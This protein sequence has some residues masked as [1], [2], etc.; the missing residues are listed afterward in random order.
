M[1]S[2]LHFLLALTSLFVSFAQEP[3]QRDSIT[4]L[5]E[6]ILLDS[7]QS[8]TDNGII[9]TKIIGTK[10]FQNYSPVD[11]VSAINQIS[12]VYIL[13]GALNTNRITIRGVGAR[14]LFGTDKL[15]LYYND[16]PITNGSGFSTI[17]SFDLENLSS[18][19]VIKGPKATNYGAN[20]GGAILLNSKQPTNESTYFRNNFTVGSYSLV[21]NNLQ[22]SLKEN[23]VALNFHYGFLETDG[24]RENNKFKRE[25]VLLDLNYQITPKTNIGLLFNHV[26]YN[27]Q[28]PSSLGETDFRENPTKAAFTWKS[29]KGYE[30][31]KYSLAG[32]TLNHAFSAKLSN[33]T[34]IFY[35]YLDHYEPRPFGILEEYTNGYGFR[36]KFAGHW[37]TNNSKIDYNFGAELYKDEYQWSEFENL[38]QDNNGQGS[39][40]GDQFA[41]NKEFRRQFNAFGNLLIPFGKSFSTQ[42]GLNVNKTYY[43]F[44]D[45]FN[46]GADNKSAER[47]FDAIVLP[48]LNLNYNFSTTKSIYAN[49]SRGFSNPTVEETLT[50]DGVINPDIAQETGV[51][52]EIGSKLLLL[53][54]KLSINLALYRMDIKNLLVAQRVGEDQYIGK[55]AGKTQ[56][57]GLELDMEYNWDIASKLRVT[58]FISYTYNDHSFV[59]FVDGDNNY[60]GNPLTGVPKHRLNSGLQAQ[61]NNKFY[62]YSTHQYVGEIPLTDANELYSD[63]FNVV[64][65]KVGYKNQLGKKLSMDIAFGINNIFDRN[66]A[67]SVLINTTGFG[68]AEPRYYYPGN[69]RNYYGSLRLGYSL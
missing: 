52:Y 45:E 25:G 57:Q 48:S 69:D 21:K 24:Y 31:N 56:H 19:E 47:D 58:P 46:Q 65:S 66:Y 44:R 32:L 63:A 8:A 68:G 53:D 3:I 23:K 20:L 7:L 35:S 18:V 16:I 43:D 28:I 38:Y 26:D 22:F 27:A 64:N 4:E 34:S 60:S 12:G 37:A 59:T 54:R 33:T 6:V 5:D 42:I 11:M 13:S 40:Q 36:T 30:D 55:N 9:A 1:K 29:A 51:N 62:W 50:P 2:S 15:R 39:L 41:N 10:V 14:T 49:I 61:L 67:Q 17:E